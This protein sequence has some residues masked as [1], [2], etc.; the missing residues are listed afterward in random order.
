MARKKKSSKKARK[1]QTLTEAK[2]EAQS[3]LN[4]TTIRRFQK[5][6]NMN[7]LSELDKTGE[8]LTQTDPTV[9][10]KG[11]KTTGGSEAGLKKTGEEVTQKKETEIKGSAATAAQKTDEQQLREQ[12]ELG[13]EDEELGMEDEELGMEDE[14][15]G[16]EDEGAVVDEGTVEDL[17]SAIADA[18][19]DTTG[20]PVNVEGGDEE[21]LEGLEGEEDFEDLEGEEG[22]EGLEDEGEGEM[23]PPEEEM[24]QESYDP[25]Q[26]RN[27]LISEVSNRIRARAQHEQQQRALYEQQLQQQALY[28]HQVKQQAVAQQEAKKQQ[29]AESL[30]NRIFTRLKG[31]KQKK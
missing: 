3:L 24:M 27:Y 6:A 7:V 20:I 30:A 19:T 11:K 12:K 10:T 25:Q 28:E 2:T 29:L 23:M 9:F 18:I 21:D 8:E 1:A 14:E 16:M 13:M 17:V 5:L 15:L 26:L 4:E 22:L 31:K